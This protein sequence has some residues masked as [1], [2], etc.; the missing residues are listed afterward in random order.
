MKITEMHV[1]GFRSLRDVLWRPGAL[2]VVIGPNA[3][4]KSNLLKALEML[5]ASARGEMGEFVRREGGME[6]LAWNST[7]ERIHLNVTSR[8]HQ[9]STN[10]LRLPPVED[11]HYVLKLPRVG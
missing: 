4:G 10:E 5:S 1:E 8:W 3:S 6:S 2:N 7:A 9:Q 11:F